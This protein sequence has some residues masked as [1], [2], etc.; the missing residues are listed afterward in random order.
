MDKRLS[1]VSGVSLITYTNT[2]TENKHIDVFVCFKK[3]RVKATNNQLVLF[4]LLFLGTINYSMIRNR[5][6]NESEI[7][8]FVLKAFNLLNV[9]VLQSVL[10]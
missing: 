10:I 8:S 2:R 4:V 1:D 3:N 9:S 7:L 5:V 6:R